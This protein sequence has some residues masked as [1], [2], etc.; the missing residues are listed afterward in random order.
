MRLTQWTDYSLRVLMYCAATQQRAQAATVAEIAESHGI[1]RH[2]LTKVVMALAAQGWIVTLRGRGGGLR[3]VRPA[4]QIVL[5]EVVRQTER[6]FDMV[7]CFDK[8]RNTCRIDGLCGLK[9][10][11]KRA[12]DSYLATLDGVTLADLV[13][14]PGA[15]IP[16]S[17]PTPTAR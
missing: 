12:T 14:A 16:L 13:P 10:A 15:T 8:A 1:S 11:L 17:W 9:G 6:D 7:E 3:L 5:G 4:E 2:H